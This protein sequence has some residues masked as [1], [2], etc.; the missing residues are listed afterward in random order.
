MRDIFLGNTNYLY[1]MD[2]SFLYCKGEKTLLVKIYIF[3]FQFLSLFH[4]S[5]VCI[6]IYICM[7]IVYI[8]IYVYVYILDITHIFWVISNIQ[9][10]LISTASKQ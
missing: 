9:L 2:I 1:P 6:N 8:Y 10:R 3:H 4:F 5:C 7:Y